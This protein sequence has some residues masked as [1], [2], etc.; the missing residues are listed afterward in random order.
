VFLNSFNHI[1]SQNLWKS[2]KSL[3][4]RVQNQDTMWDSDGQHEVSPGLSGSL[5]PIPQGFDS[6]ESRQYCDSAT[7]KSIR[8]G[9]RRNWSGVD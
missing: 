6:T 7:S 5:P 1:Y 3:L 8:K 4:E 9:F 2:K